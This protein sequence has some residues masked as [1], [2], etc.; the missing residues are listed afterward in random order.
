MLDVVWLP[1]A[2]TDYYENIDFIL[3]K[4]SITET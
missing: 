4:W 2:E 1:E 3:Q